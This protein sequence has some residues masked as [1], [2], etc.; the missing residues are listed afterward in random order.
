MIMTSKR[1]PKTFNTEEQRKQ[2][3]GRKSRRKYGRD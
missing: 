2:R 1:K 3:Y